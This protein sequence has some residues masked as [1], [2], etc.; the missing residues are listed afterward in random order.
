[1]SRSNG[2]LGWRVAL[3]AFASA[4]IVAATAF[5]RSAAADDD[6][7]GQRGQWGEQGDNGGYG[8]GGYYYAPPPGYYALP[9]PAY[10]PPP[11]AYYPPPAYYGPPPPAY[12]GP[13][14]VGFQF[15]IPFR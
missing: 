12:Y 10:Y 14:Q 1:M 6:G 9:P 11:Q 5:P 8:N 7:E 2:S 4:A 13:P 3:M 15:V